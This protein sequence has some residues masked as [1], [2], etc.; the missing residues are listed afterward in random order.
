MP[1]G[2]FIESLKD[3]KGEVI[4]FENSYTN[5]KKYIENSFNDFKKINKD[6]NL[7]NGLFNKSIEEHIKFIKEKC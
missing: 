5:D 2:T 6:I 7:S 1:V 4:L 3:Y